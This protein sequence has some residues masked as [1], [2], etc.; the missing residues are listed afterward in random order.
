MISLTNTWITG[1]VIHGDGRGRT[2]GFP[3]A[4]IVRITPSI[5]L[6]PGVY[7][8]WVTMPD[9][10]IY[11]GAMHV[12]PR[13]TFDDETSTVEIHVLNWNDSDFYGEALSF[14]VI[15]KLRDIEKFDTVE[16][17]V[18]AIQHDCTIVE[19]YLSTPPAF[20]NA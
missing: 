19:K 6:S 8:S 5:T 7:A 20:D 16:S 11:K 18:E 17:L 12:G 2:I 14:I 15:K 9:G 3:T 4:N 13:P 1:T 10:K